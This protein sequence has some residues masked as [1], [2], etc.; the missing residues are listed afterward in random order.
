MR[1]SILIAVSLL[2]VALAGCSDDPPSGEISGSSV[3]VPAAGTIELSET[4]FNEPGPVANPNQPGQT[5]PGRET[6]GQQQCTYPSSV[7]TIHLMSLPNPLNEQYTVTLVSSSAATMDLG[8]LTATANG[9][10]AMYDLVY[11]NTD[12]CDNSYS[13]DGCV[14]SD[15]F[16]EIYVY[17]GELLVAIGPLQNGGSFEANPAFAG[18]SFS[19][20]YEN[21]DA[22]VELTG[23]GNFTYDLVLYTA[24]EAG[25]I[26]AVEDYTV[27]PGSN[28][29][30]A[31]MSWDKYAEV[32][33]H[34]AGTK[35]NLAKASVA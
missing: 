5:C 11:D 8:P 18:H 14:L 19:L 6:A 31:E 20:T 16:D 10:E 17:M 23:N 25:E 13:D 24:D 35:V 30:T 27:S 3:A 33:V 2:A 7:L 4:R 32:H 28:E 22:T 15:Q 1:T 26:T 9:T 34:V 12:D 21:K 29:V